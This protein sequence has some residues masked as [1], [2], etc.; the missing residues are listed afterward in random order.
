MAQVEANVPLGLNSDSLAYYMYD[1]NKQSRYRLWTNSKTI[2]HN[3][4]GGINISYKMYKNFVLNTNASFA[5]LQSKSNNDGFEEAFNTPR[6]ICNV[7]ISNTRLTKNIGFGINY[8]YQE[9]FLWQSSLANGIVPEIHNLDAQISYHWQK[10]GIQMKLTGNNIF[11][12]PYVSFIAAP[13]I[14]AF[15]TIIIRYDIVK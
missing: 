9:R 7:G 8:K 12:R 15:Y 3:Y 11:N 4:G 6:W 2:V 5:Q 14:G 1:R 13:T 10:K